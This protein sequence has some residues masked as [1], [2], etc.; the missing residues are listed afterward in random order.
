MLFV[1]IVRN[2][3]IAQLYTRV[4]S[5]QASLSCCTK[6]RQVGDIRMHES[7]FSLNSLH[8]RPGGSL[9][10]SAI[11]VVCADV[12]GVTQCGV[13]AHAS[14]SLPGS[15]VCDDVRLFSVPGSLVWC[16]GVCV[17]FFAWLN[18]VMCLLSV[19]DSLVCRDASCYYISSKAQ[20]S[21]HS[22]SH[23]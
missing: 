19:L 20:V 6:R 22:H 1:S 4:R 18:G 23:R 13:R 5:I 17:I 8:R 10:F 14:F 21:L 7:Q 9:R 3:W 15:M 2:E 16:E 12:T 11:A